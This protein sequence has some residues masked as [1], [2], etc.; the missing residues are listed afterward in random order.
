MILEIYD[1][2]AFFDFLGVP[3]NSDSSA[4]SLALFL[5]TGSFDTSDCLFFFFF[6]LGV[7]SFLQRN[8]KVT[9]LFNQSITLTIVFLKVM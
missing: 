5:D 8:G 2:L 6:F 4:D 3:T 9:N 7:I 1:I